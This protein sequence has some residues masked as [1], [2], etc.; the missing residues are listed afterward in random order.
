MPESLSFTVTGNAVPKQSFRFGGRGRTGHGYQ[1][2]RVR[3]W[4][5]EVACAA[6]QV[7][8]D[9]PWT[10]DVA[11]SVSFTLTHRRRVDLDNLYKGTCDALKGILFEDD[12]Q[13][14]QLQLAKRQPA[15]PAQTVITAR[16]LTSPPAP[17]PRLFPAP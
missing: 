1:P 13:I 9:A 2:A 3:A 17:P 16:R 5:A 14:V 4:Q 7:Y 10:G 12:C 11:L 15:R 8:Q 6:R